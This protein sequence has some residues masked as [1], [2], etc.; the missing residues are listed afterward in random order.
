MGKVC[1]PLCLFTALKLY[2]IGILHNKLLNVYLKFIS[3]T[4]AIAERIVFTLKIVLSEASF[5]MVRQ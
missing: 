5:K 4:E 3:V 1:T 2:W